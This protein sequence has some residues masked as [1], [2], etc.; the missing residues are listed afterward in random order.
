[1][2]SPNCLEYRLGNIIDAWYAEA[3]LRGKSRSMESLSSLASAHEKTFAGHLLQHP[4]RYTQPVSAELEERLIEYWWIYDYALIHELKM[5]FTLS[6]RDAIK[7]YFG[8]CWGAASEGECVVHFRVGDVFAPKWN[9]GAITIDSF[10]NAASKFSRTPSRFQVLT[11]GLHQT[12]E[13]R[14][15]QKSVALLESLKR[16]FEARFPDALVEFSIDTPDADRDFLKMVAAPMLL[17]ATGSYATVAAI[18]NPH[19]RLTPAVR[20]LLMAEASDEEVAPTRIFE[21]WNTYAVRAVRPEAV[22]GMILAADQR[23]HG[24]EPLNAFEALV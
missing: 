24:V 6:I 16:A 14:L 13:P 8:A 23:R 10:V 21:N 7:E 20:Y 4:P 15:R 1:M 11:G 19:E 5:G 12:T 9:F 3:L 17:A 18:A 22:D 2:S